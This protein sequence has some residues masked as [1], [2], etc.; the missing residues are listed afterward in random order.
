MDCIGN[1]AVSTQ[2]TWHVAEQS[3]LLYSLQECLTAWRWLQRLACHGVIPYNAAIYSAST[4]ANCRPSPNTARLVMH[5][6]Y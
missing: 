5:S 4:L 6:P 2:V 1:F 3:L